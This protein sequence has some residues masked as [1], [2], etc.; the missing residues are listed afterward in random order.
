MREGKTPSS[1]TCNPLI[2]IV[3]VFLSAY[4][5]VQYCTYR[6]KPRWRNESL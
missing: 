1:S 5:K 4:C 3:T 2:F 6:R